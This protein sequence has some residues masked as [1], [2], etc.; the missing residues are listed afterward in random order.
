M[1]AKQL[2]STGG[3]KIMSSSSKII[4]GS[5]TKNS[6][7]R[8][9]VMSSSSKIIDGSKTFI[10]SACLYFRSSSSKIIDGSKTVITAERRRIFV[11]F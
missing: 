7:V 1:V 10:R 4:D 8:K 5:K 2:A 3:V 9:V 6:C 11:I